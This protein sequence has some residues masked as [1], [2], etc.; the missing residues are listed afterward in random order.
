MI[1]SGIA[2]A[3]RYKILPV[4]DYEDRRVVAGNDARIA[5]FPAR[6]DQDR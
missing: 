3:K 1:A 6:V 5:A 2:C 4:F